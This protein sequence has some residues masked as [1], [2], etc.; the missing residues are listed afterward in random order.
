MVRDDVGI[1]AVWAKPCG[2]PTQALAAGVGLARHSEH[3]L[4]NGSLHRS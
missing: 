2:T 4:T 3:H 1:A